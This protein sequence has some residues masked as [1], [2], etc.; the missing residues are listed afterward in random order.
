MVPPTWTIHDCD[1]SAELHR[2][3]FTFAAGGQGVL[4][5]CRDD[6]L[7][8]KTLSNT[9]MKK[10]NDHDANLHT[11]DTEYT[12]SPGAEARLN[13]PAPDDLPLFGKEFS[14]AHVDALVLALSR[15]QRIFTQRQVEKLE[16]WA[17]MAIFNFRALEMIFEGLLKVS[18]RP[19]GELV[20]YAVRPED[21]ANPSAGENNQG[22]KFN[23]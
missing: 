4:K 6:S 20:F 2:G 19:D 18:L 15:G 11:K 1:D 22:P 21:S 5:R 12:L 23:S 16:E 8:P 3:P 10:H 7:K 13:L 17:R 9:T 14:A